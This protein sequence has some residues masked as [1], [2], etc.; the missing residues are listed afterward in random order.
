VPFSSIRDGSRVTHVLVAEAPGVVIFAGIVYTQTH[1][2]SIFF[3][4][5]TSTVTSTTATETSKFNVTSPSSSLIETSCF[6]DN[7]GH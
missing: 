5:T 1:S 3:A 6:H 4:A 7:D 2:Q